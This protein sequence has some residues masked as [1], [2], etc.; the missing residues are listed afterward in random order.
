MA[1]TESPQ[2]DPESEEAKPALPPPEGRP[3]EEWAAKAERAREA[4]ALGRRLRKGKRLVFS[5][6]RHLAS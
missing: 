6:R 3:A 5:S 1:T 2:P 4:R